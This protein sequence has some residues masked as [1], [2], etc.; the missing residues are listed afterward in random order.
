MLTIDN[1]LTKVKSAMTIDATNTYSDDTLKV[2]ILDAIDY[3]DNAGVAESLIYSDKAMGVIS[4]CVIDA[5]Q[6]GGNFTVS[7]RIQQRVKQL[8]MKSEIIPLETQL[9]ETQKQLVTANAELL[10]LTNQIAPLNAQLNILTTSKL[11]LDAQL[12]ANSLE[13]NNLNSQK[14]SLNAQL[15][16]LNQQKSALEAQIL[17]NNNDIN[18]LL[19][20]ISATNVYINDLN[21][22]IITLN[23]N[24]SS[25]ND[26]LIAYNSNFEAIRTSITNKGI[27]AMSTQPAGLSALIDTIEVPVTSSVSRITI[28]INRIGNVNGAFYNNNTVTKVDL[29]KFDLTPYTYLLG[30][31]W[32]CVELLSIVGLDK[33][34]TQNVTSMKEMFYSC[35]KL[36]S[37]DVS[38]FNTSKVTNM[39]AMFGSLYV[40]T[41]L[42]VSSF[43]MTKVLD[44]GYMF[45]F[46][47]YK[48]VGFSLNSDIQSTGINANTFG[49]ITGLLFKTGGTLGGYSTAPSLTFYIKNLNYQAALDMFNSISANI[50]GRTRIIVLSTATYNS[51]S[52]IEKAI[53]TN[54]GYSL[55]YE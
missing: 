33:M 53:L 11:A 25:L 15:N 2:Y 40:M 1:I 51:L 38:H 8:S 4:M 52:N 26:A 43:D 41:F 3:M 21:N 9:K 54:K 31:F 46:S 55:S 14:T 35:T 49:T 34:N 6:L 28:E 12:I 36:K 24:I 23:S 16:I 30:M 20:Q 19:N 18:N 10:I 48:V 37:V 29:S 47:T 27:N 32:G 5:W 44:I 50:S 45:A 13:I 7:P 42:D 39:N 22:Q 17:A